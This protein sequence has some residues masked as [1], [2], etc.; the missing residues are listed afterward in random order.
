MTRSLLVLS[1]LLLGACGGGGNSGDTSNDH[2]PPVDDV[3]PCSQTTAGQVNWTALM[4][5]EC[6]QLTQY[7]L[8]QDPQ[9]PTSSP[10]APGQAYDLSTQLFTDHAVKFRFLFLPRGQSMQFQPEEV[11]SLPVGSVLV[12]SFTLPADTDQREGGELALVETRLLIHRQSGWT[13]LVYQWQQGEAT[14]LDTGASVPHTLTHQGESISFNYSIPS[15]VECKICHQQRQEDGTSPIWP[16]GLQPHLLQLPGDNQLVRWQQQGQ[17]EGLPQEALPWA[18]PLTD[19]QGDLTVRVKGYL[20]VN[21]AHCHNPRGHASLSGLR[22]GFYEDHT[23]S[24]YGI[25]KQPPG[26]DGGPRGLDYD[27]VPGNGQDSI[28]PYRMELRQPKDRMPMLGRNLV[29]R[30]AVDLVRQW[31][32]ALSPSL[33]EC[34]N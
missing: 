7:G 22:L 23:Q 6:R 28:L 34:Q 17:L 19:A 2:P 14:L 15:R 26:W 33:G 18:P 5:A 25:C 8:F 20:D 10:N 31:I 16:I 21:C 12:K 24:S 32:D 3:G 9:D 11:L 29:H 4:E 30:E 13:A 1:W 27:I